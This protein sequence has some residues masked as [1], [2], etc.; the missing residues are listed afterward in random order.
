V[1][2]AAPEP[3]VSFE[4]FLLIFH[5]SNTN[6]ISVKKPSEKELLGKSGVDERRV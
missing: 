4:Y 2:F 1:L 5:I 6:T 3:H